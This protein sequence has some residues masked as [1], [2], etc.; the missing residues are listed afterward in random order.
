[1]ESLL[2]ENSKI[3]WTTHTF[4]PWIGC[5]KVSTG[6]D[7][8]YAESLAKR[9]GWVEWGQR[10]TAATEASVGGRKRTSEANWKKPRQWAKAARGTGKRPRVFCASLADVFDN[11]VPAEW[12]AD[13]FQMIYETPEL[14]WLLLTK[15]PENIQKMLIPKAWAN[16]W[17]GTTCEDQDAYDRRWPILRECPATVH[18]ISYEPAIGPLRLHNG[19]DQPDWLI[20]GGESGPGA[21]YM[22]PAWAVDIRNDCERTGTYFFMKQMTG[23]KPIP[24]YLMLREF[25]R[26]AA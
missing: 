12:R 20:C 19:P 10:K 9:Y 24:E 16:L 23:K 11:Q 21:R 14:D 8:C 7:H 3:E 18:F 5:M 15:R 6:C 4:N 22:L 25:P 1:L 17:L 26:S 2:A 13:L